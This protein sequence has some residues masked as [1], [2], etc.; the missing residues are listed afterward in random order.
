MAQ[1]RSIAPTSVVALLLCGSWWY[2]LQSQFPLS[3]DVQCWF[4]DPHRQELSPSEVLSAAA[5][6]LA[7]LLA[8]AMARTD[9]R[10]G[11]AAVACAGMLLEETNY[12]VPLLTALAGEYRTG[13]SFHNII[14]ATD[15]DTYWLIEVLAKDVMLASAYFAVP[16]LTAWRKRSLRDRV[17]GRFP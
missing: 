10:W 17:G 1:R 14:E 2:V 4:F 11:L 6:L 12:G 15:Q 16:V 9:G 3:M 7:A 13:Y 8:S 5:W